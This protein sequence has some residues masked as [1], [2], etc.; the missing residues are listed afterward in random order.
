MSLFSL[1]VKH[2]Q[3]LLVPILSVCLLSCERFLDAKP[4]QTLTVPSSIR[5]LWAMIDNNNTFNTRCASASEILSDNYYL[6]DESW[7]AI[8]SEVQRAEYL[9]ER[10]DDTNLDWLNYSAIRTSNA[11][12]ETLPKIN[13]PDVKADELKHIKG[14]ALFFRGYYFYTLAQLFCLPYNPQTV[15]QKYGLPLR[16]DTDFEKPSVR[17]T[18][19]ETYQQILHDL[20]ESVSLLPIIPLVKTRPGKPAAYGMI[21]KTYLSMQ[22]YDSAGVYAGKCLALYDSLMNFGAEVD[23]QSPAPFNRFNKEVI[24]HAVS[25]RT[26]I[27][28]PAYAKVD[29]LL[30]KSYADNDLRKIAYF[31]A[32]TGSDLGTYSFKGDY[33]GAGTSGGFVFAGVVTDDMYLIRAE[34]NARKGN[35]HLALQDL[36]TLLENRFSHPYTPIVTTDAKEALKVILAERRKEL[37]FRG[38]RWTDLRRLKDDPELSVVPERHIN[39]QTYR[40]LPNSNGYVISFPAVVMSHTDMEQNP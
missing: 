28:M 10:N 12:L 2:I 25:S 23:I 5:D 26:T 38:A 1:K 14:S 32:N 13:F 33:D 7:A 16:T 8:R 6:T 29:S 31:N 9:W 3:I 36:N 18:V 22:Q 11:V 15:S 30:Y 24:F 34:C 37:L 4:D 19:E 35:G 17:S 39:G 20:K 27:L 40:L 21:A